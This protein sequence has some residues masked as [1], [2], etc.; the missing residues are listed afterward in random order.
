MSHEQGV[1][2]IKVGSPE[3]EAQ[4]VEHAPPT[5]LPARL[6]F[7]CLHL[8]EDL[9]GL[10]ILDVGAGGSSMIADL[11][12][13]GA[14]AYAV[15][16]KYKSR[17]DMKGRILNHNKTGFAEKEDQIIRNE[18]LERFLQSIKQ[19]PERYKVAYATNLPFPDEHFDLVF[20]IA[21]VTVYSDL[22]K[23]V[24][25]KIM[26]EI[27]RVTKPGGQIQLYPLQEANV[28][29]D[30]SVD[31]MRLN[32]QAEVF[33]NLKNKGKVVEFQIMDVEATGMKTLIMTKPA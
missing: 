15:D 6:A 4:L 21:A 2:E 23:L 29:F 32:N 27:V 25:K 28:G 3:S 14:D 24:L 1:F 5:S 11:L 17:A 12:E 19:N 10:R 33:N 7:D 8:P 9:Q 16:P 26:D 22:D 31:N 18:A 13:K 20:S 30:E